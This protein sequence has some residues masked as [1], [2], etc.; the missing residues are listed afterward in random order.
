MN[1][2]NKKNIRLSLTQ[3]L[4]AI[5]LAFVVIF[6]AFFFSY[7]NNSIN[8]FVRIEMDNFLSSSQ[9]SII[10]AYEINNNGKF[11]HNLKEE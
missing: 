11:L 6:L 4:V 9:T 5:V 10:E 8:E 2:L 7:L 1:K 3:Q